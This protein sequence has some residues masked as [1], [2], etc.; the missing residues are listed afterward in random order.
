MDYESHYLRLMAKAKRRKIESPL[1]GY[2][3]R[4][5]VIPRCVGGGDEANNLVDLTADEHFV[6]H[7]LLVKMFP[8]ERALIFALKRM[9][10]FSRRLRIDHADLSRRRLYTWSRKALA[11]AISQMN[12]GR[13]RTKEAN[14]GTSA[15]LRGKKKSPEHRAKIVAALRTPERQ[16]KLLEATRRPKSEEHR[17][18]ISEGGRTAWKS[19]PGRR[20]Q[21]IANL[22]KRIRSREAKLLDCGGGEGVGLDPESGRRAEATGLRHAGH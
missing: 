5:H 15:G 18:K 9:T 13:V 8:E 20:L 11:A 12:S 17:R 7:E 3:E 21:Q 1:V 19:S 4:H 22:K 16:A 6:A 2:K 10:H 14:A